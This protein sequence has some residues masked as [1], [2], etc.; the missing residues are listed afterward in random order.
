[1]GIQ[2]YKDVVITAAIGQVIILEIYV[3]DKYRTLVGGIPMYGTVPLA[4]CIAV[5]PTL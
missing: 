2:I 5:M 4:S 3:H 1:M